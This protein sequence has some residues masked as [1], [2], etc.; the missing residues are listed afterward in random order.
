M[1]R[2]PRKIATKT[3][4]LL[5]MLVTAGVALAQQT[6]S[7]APPQQQ[8]ERIEP[9]SDT[10]VTITP[11]TR[12]KNKI[13]QTKEGGRV[14]EVQVSAGGS[15]YTMKGVRPGSVAEMNAQGGSTVQPPQWK[16]LEFDMNKKKKSDPE[17][18]GADTT[19]NAPPPQTVK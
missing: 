1:A 3:A 7:A 4:F 6:P 14:K 9:G 11:Q 5:S 19:V 10:P 2:T 12:S 8:L 13:S 16:V 17:A 15:H 18:A